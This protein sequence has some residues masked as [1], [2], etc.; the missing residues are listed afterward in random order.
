MARY[1]KIVA[2]FAR[3]FEREAAIHYTAI[4]NPVLCDL[5]ATC[6]SPCLIRNQYDNWNYV[7]KKLALPANMC[8]QH[9]ELDNVTLSVLLLIFLYNGLLNVTWS[10]GSLR[11]NLGC[12]GHKRVL[13]LSHEDTRTLEW[14]SHTRSESWVKNRHLWRIK[15]QLRWRDLRMAL[16]LQNG[17]S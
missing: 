5:V 4:V 3:I 15:L 14:S 17:W 7:Y 9:W 10:K 6:I 11:S 13:L 1:K 16:A 8:G 12:M 2:Q